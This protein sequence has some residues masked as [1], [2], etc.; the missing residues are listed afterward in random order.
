MTTSSGV[1]F[2]IGET[3]NPVI[4]AIKNTIAGAMGFGG[5]LLMVNTAENA[6]KTRKVLQDVY[7]KK[8]TSKV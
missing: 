5:M 6:T 3:P 8:S 7:D 2:S 4:N 1:L